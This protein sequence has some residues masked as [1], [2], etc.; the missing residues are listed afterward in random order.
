[1]DYG[2]RF[3]PRSFLFVLRTL[4]HASQAAQEDD[5]IESNCNKGERADNYF[6]V[7]K[8]SAADVVLLKRESWEIRSRGW[9]LKCATS[10]RAALAEKKL[11][12]LPFKSNAIFLEASYPLSLPLFAQIAGEHEKAVSF[13]FKIDAEKRVTATVCVAEQ[14]TQ[15][16]HNYRTRARTF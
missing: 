2:E 9:P 11:A 1:V 5:C 15:S 4:S 13:L 6:I 3:I 8:R 12:T 10:L 7:C 16:P 14:S